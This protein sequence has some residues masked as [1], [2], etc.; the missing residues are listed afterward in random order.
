MRR[1]SSTSRGPPGPPLHP[2]SVDI[3][4]IHAW[5]TVISGRRGEERDSDWQVN[6]PAVCATKANWIEKEAQISITTEGPG[7]VGTE[8]T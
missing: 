8:P 5:W 7:T 2:S 1:P 4:A 3:F 6:L